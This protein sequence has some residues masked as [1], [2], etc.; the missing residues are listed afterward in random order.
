[1]ARRRYQKGHLSLR[2]KRQKVW[3]AQWR[4]DVVGP[5]GA[6][7]RIRHKEVLGT[8]AEFPTKKL[9]QRALDDKLSDVNS[10]T[11]KPR[12]ATTFE[13]F[14]HRW[15]RDVLSQLKRS[16][17]STERSRL[18]NHILPA[19]GHLQVREINTQL[20]Q[21][22][23]VAAK[24]KQMS[25][26]SVRNLI[27]TLRIMWSTVR[28]WGYTSVNPIDGLVLPETG[29][30]EQRFFT[31]DEMRRIIN[32]APEPHKTCYWILAETGIRAGEVFGLPTR[33]LMLELPAIRITQS[34]WGGKIQTVKSVKGRRV[35]EISPQLA[36]HLRRFLETWQP[37]EKDLLFA[38]RNGTPVDKDLM[39]RRKLKP[40]LTTLGIEHAGF[41]AFR[42]GNES[43]MGRDLVPMLIRSNRMGHSDA[44][45]TMR[46]EHVISEDGRRFAENIGR[47]LTEVVQ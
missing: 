41:H 4:E 35:C 16:T 13:E 34:V 38:T 25:A 26:K 10:L 24:L 33:D 11:Y 20:I 21:Q 46:Y 12:P 8:L 40:L 7:Q 27:A 1:M 15:E 6:V 9:A 36:E 44:R 14:A 22:F 39:R 30:Q 19:L 31:L 23:L 18:R 2:G 28:A 43:I 3:V 17:I 37:N 32:A 42:H 29:L 47:L 5:D 45:T